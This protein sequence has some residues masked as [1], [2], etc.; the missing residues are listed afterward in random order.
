M[1]YSTDLNCSN[2]TSTT[3]QHL[4]VHDIFIYFNTDRNT[5]ETGI[6]DILLLATLTRDL[7]SGVIP[8]PKCQSGTVPPARQGRWGP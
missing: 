1:T 7:K 6:T 3:Y 2:N 4:V 8:T 5:D